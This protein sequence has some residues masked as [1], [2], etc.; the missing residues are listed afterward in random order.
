MGFGNNPLQW[1]TILLAL[2]LVG[3]CVT[4]TTS[5]PRIETADESEAFERHMNLAM[6]YIDNGNRNLANV[7]LE[8]A[9]AIDARAAE[10]N[11]GYALLYQKDGEHKLAHEYYAR[12]LRAKPGFSAA[13]YT[14]AA[15]LFNQQEY[16]ESAEQMAKVTEDLAY[17]RRA[18]AFYILGLS[19]QRL[20]NDGGAAEAFEKALQLSPR[21]APAWLELAQI[22]FDQQDFPRAK[23]MLATFQQLSSPT[24]ASLWLAVR[25]EDRFGNRDGVAS[26]G[27]KLKNMF[28]YSEENLQY[29]AW[30]KS[31]K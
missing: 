30:L 18:E 26:E 24:A 14:Y 29:Q 31:P 22:A 10:L 15:Y 6:Q 7:H 28:P 9:S 25:V 2:C 12:A 21:L 19:R 4:T 23:R 8:K 13:R 1:T 20:G 17:Q 3:G 5:K 27:L 16:A 11:Y